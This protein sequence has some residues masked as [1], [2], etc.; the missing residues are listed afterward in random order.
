MIITKNWVITYKSITYMII[1][2]QIR[3]EGMELYW[4]TVCMFHQNLVITGVK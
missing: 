2:S 4:S 3:V 1:T